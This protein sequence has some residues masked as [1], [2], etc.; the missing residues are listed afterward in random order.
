MMSLVSRSI[1]VRSYASLSLCKF[2]LMQVC[3]CASLPLCK[4]VYASSF[5]ASLFFA[6]SFLQVRSMHAHSISFMHACLCKPVLYRFVLCMSVRC[7]FILMQGCC[8]ASSSFTRRRD[9]VCA[10]HYSIRDPLRWRLYE[11]TGR[12]NA[13]VNA[14]RMSLFF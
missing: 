13:V 6:S 5:Y 1:I 8:Y 12:V 11:L 3:H 2:V 14:F 9:S 4:L 10:L 7:M